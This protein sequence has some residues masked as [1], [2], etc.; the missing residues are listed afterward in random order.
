MSKVMIIAELSANHNHKKEIALDVNP[1]VNN[2]FTTINKVDKLNKRK[3]SKETTDL[4]KLELIF[5]YLTGNK[6]KHERYLE[7]LK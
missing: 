4:Q 1:F 6:G 7:F 3:Q 2:L 5:N